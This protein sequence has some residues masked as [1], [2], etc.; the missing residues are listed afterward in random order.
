M[1]YF[2]IYYIVPETPIFFLPVILD[3]MNIYFG[4]LDYFWLL[5]YDYFVVR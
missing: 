3:Y 2:G 4:F 5:I 1:I